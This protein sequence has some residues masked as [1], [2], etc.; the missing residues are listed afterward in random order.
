MGF[1]SAFKGLK[2]V[3]NPGNRRLNNL[4]DPVLNVLIRLT[5]NT[6]TT[7]LTVTQSKWMPAMPYKNDFIDRSLKIHDTNLPTP[8]A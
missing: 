4:N 7:T 3:K 5:V 1:N 8:K 2:F 6:V